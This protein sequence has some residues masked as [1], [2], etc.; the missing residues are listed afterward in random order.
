MLS[1][2]KTTIDM[3][4]IMGTNHE[5]Y[6]NISQWGRD[7]Q[8]QLVLIRGQHPTLTN[9]AIILSQIRYRWFLSRSDTVIKTMNAEQT[10]ST[11][12]VIAGTGGEDTVPPTEM[13]SVQAL[14]ALRNAADL[15]NDNSYIILN[16]AANMIER[17][18]EDGFI[19]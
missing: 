15:A 4:T 8:G 18:I 13:E 1:F 2:D 3:E 17:I 5:R 12:A 14:E 16:M 9:A 10:I 6:I 11:W 7:D 19:D